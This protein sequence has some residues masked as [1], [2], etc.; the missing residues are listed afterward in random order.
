MKRT[1]V[2]I[3]SMLVILTFVT[4]C[5]GKSA[6]PKASDNVAVAEDDFDAHG[7]KGKVAITFE[8]DKIV[9]VQYDEL[10]KKGD[11][12]S[13]DKAYAAQMEPAA[14]VT[15]AE[16]GEQLA[17]SLV[18]TQDVSKVDTVTGATEITARFKEL[19]EKALS[20]R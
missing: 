2:L 9:K 6:F 7:W 16:A 5:G 12:K 1:L 4:A 19:A 20:S 18:K 3:G 13:G 8:G 14:G 11:L 10:N 15:P 17:A